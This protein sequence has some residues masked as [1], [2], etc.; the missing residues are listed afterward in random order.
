M[1]SGGTS[2]T[3]AATVAGK[4]NQLGSGAF[5]KFGA[6]SSF[7]RIAGVAAGVVFCCVVWPGF[8]A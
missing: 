4:A 5:G 3:V 7:S 2:G 1:D 8:G 6:E